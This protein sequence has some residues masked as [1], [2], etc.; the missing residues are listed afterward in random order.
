MKKPNI[1]AIGLL[2]TVVG[3]GVS[4]A[5]SIVSGKQQDNA[6]KEAVDKAVEAKL[7]K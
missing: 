2:L 6:I 5:S 4:V 1:K 3:A 7:G